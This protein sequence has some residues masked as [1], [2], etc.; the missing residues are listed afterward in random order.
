MYLAVA[1]KITHVEVLKTQLHVNI[2]NEIKFL[3]EHET[4]CSVYI[5]QECFVDMR[6]RNEIKSYEYNKFVHFGNE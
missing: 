5:Q 2:Q 1:T 6:T 3:D 4:I